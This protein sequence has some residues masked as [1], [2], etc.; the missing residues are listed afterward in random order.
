MIFGVLLAA[1]SG[2]RMVSAKIPKQF[3]KLNDI[4]LLNLTVNKFLASPL[5]D[6]IVVVAPSIWLSHTKDLLKD[7]LY[8]N[9]DIC[10]GGKTRQES[11]YK[12]VNFI[13]E[14]YHVTDDDI[15]VSHDVARP[16]VSLRI[17][18]DNIQLMKKYDA[19]DTVIPA[20]DTIVQ[21]IDGLSLSSIPERKQMYQGQT[22]Q[23]F[24]LT[25]Y[26]QIYANL[27][28]KYLE[29]ITDAAKILLEHGCSVGLAIGDE[30]NIKITTEYD[31]KIAKIL[32]QK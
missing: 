29:N 6:K 25:K 12:A 22:P 30:S 19:V 32:L 23:T 2:T 26:K 5:I 24:K 18:E 14:K 20:T 15:V 10:E 7:E 13:S 8:N 3:L 21:S 11:L 4:P 31:F 28:N 1:G 27:S 9:I 16:F 17:I